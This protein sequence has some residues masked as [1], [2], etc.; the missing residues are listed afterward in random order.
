MT[1]SHTLSFSV[2]EDDR[3]G[4]Y[5]SPLR[6][7]L[8]ATHPRDRH[9][10]NV[11]L[12]SQSAPGGQSFLLR[13]FPGLE[14]PPCN[15]QPLDFILSLPSYDVPCE[16]GSPTHSSPGPSRLGHLLL[17]KG[18]H[19]MAEP[20]SPIQFEDVPLEEARRMGRGPRMDP[21][22][23]QELR[24]RIHALSDQAV[25]LTIPDGTSQAT[26]KNRIQRVAAELG[27]PITI[28]CVSG[29]LLFW[30]STEEDIQLA[31]EVGSRLQIAQRG[32]QDRPGR[33]RRRT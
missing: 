16:P 10:F 12:M 24:T 7:A 20:L 32:R 2:R 6:C 22:L 27:V 18:S 4:Y 26:M 15:S 13:A 19:L 21:Q 8:L 29:G 31:K 30:R 14:T 3:D 5:T 25:R 17:S 33:R 23:Y 11:L 1:N 9:P 28:R